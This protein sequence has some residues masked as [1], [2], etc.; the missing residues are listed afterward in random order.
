[1]R[2]FQCTDCSRSGYPTTLQRDENTIVKWFFALI[3]QKSGPNTSF[4]S[5][6][7]SKIRTIFGT[8]F[9]EKEI[10]LFHQKYPILVTTDFEKAE[11]KK[12]CLKMIFAVYGSPMA[13]NR[14]GF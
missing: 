9:G 10:A 12:K 2:V 1:M 3:H 4:F 5:S 13:D 14:W 11:S 7:F 6:E 8:I